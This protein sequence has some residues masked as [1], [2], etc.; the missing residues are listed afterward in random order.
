[1][2]WPDTG[3][4]WT[5]WNAIRSN[6]DYGRACGV[7]GYLGVLECGPGECLVLGEE[8]M[9]TAFLP[10]QEG[11]LIVRWM[12]AECEEDVVRAVQSAPKDVWE[13]T[14]HQIHVGSGGLLLSDSA[15]PGNDLPSSS[16]EGAFPWLKVPVPKGRYE[17]DT[18]DY[19][20]DEQ[21]RL[22]LHRLRLGHS[23]SGWQ[24]QTAIVSLSTPAERHLESVHFMGRKS[25]VS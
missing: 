21:T 18:A 7:D 11:W 10:T 24:A 1:M 17:I 12:H 6:S 20:P 8:P 3:D 13:A 16:T 19:Q 23:H 4:L 22:T 15:F 9:P 5:I 25:G 2:T 14:P